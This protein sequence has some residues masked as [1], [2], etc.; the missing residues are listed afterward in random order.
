MTNPY[1]PLDPPGDT[2]GRTPKMLAGYQSTVINNGQPIPPNNAPKVLIPPEDLTFRAASRFGLRLNSMPAG[3]T[4][5]FPYQ[6]R[7]YDTRAYNMVRIGVDVYV[8][9]NAGAALR[10]EWTT[11]PL[12]DAS[13]LQAGFLGQQALVPIDIPGPAVSAP[14]AL[15]V[16]A[17]EDVWWRVVGVGGDGTTSP[18]IGIVYVQFLLG[19]L[20]LR[21]R[22]YWRNFAP[23]IS[24]PTGSGDLFDRITAD[25]SPQTEAFWGPT[26]RTWTGWL[27]PADVAAVLAAP[28]VFKRGKGTTLTGA[29][30]NANPGPAD[31][32]NHTGPLMVILGPPL[33]AQSIPAFDYKTA[34]TGVGGNGCTACWMFS[35]LL[36]YRPS[37]GSIVASSPVTS[38]LDGTW[39]RFGPRNRV[40]A[41]PIGDVTVLANDRYLLWGC[42]VMEMAGDGGCSIFGTQGIGASIG[43]NGGSD[44]PD[45]MGDASSYWQ[46]AASYTDFPR[47]LKFVTETP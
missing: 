17:I 15:A 8:E 5:Y 39:F 46:Y 29:Q 22:W 6:R 20:T 1:L 40:H 7:K 37:D 3:P 21:D 18:V 23:S 41:L 26:G 30:F 25:G 35:Q 19:Q 16:G 44:I 10:V 32:L 33:K 14:L 2:T 27:T 4:V 28:K 31:A 47:S 36:I 24:L 11:T 9:G 13:W 45:E 43:Y 34:W 12:N 38:P 42:A